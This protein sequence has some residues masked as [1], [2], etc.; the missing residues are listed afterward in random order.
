ME[1]AQPS[2][3]TK[4]RP[5]IQGLRAIAVGIVVLF[6]IWPNAIPGG[7][8]GVDVFFVISGFLITGLLVRE[9]ENSGRI[10]LVTF[11]ARRARRLLP[12]AA[13]VLVSVAVLTP[14]LLPAS[15]WSDVGYGV[16]ASLFY[17]ENWRL[18]AQAV[19]YLGAENAPGPVQH[20]WSLSVEEQFYIGWPALIIVGFAIARFTRAPVRLLLRIIFALVFAVSLYASVSLTASDPAQAYFVTH[21][22]VWELSLGGLLALGG[23]I[24]PGGLRR[25]LGVVGLI[26]IL[27]SALI[28]S[29]QTP[30]PGYA[31]LIPTL[32]AALV[33]LSGNS[34]RLLSAFSVL[35]TKPF[36]FLGDISY[37]VYLWHW[38]LLIFFRNEAGNMIEP[39]AGAFII[40]TTLGLAAFSKFQVEDVF[41]HPDPRTP[42][43]RRVVL[44]MSWL[45]AP[46]AGVSVAFGA[47]AYEGAKVAAEASRYPGAR[48]VVDGADVPPVASPAP[49]L[50]LLR[51][52]RAA[53]YD[54]GCHAK[55]EDSIPV[56]CR[57]GD[58]E[59]TY[60][61]FLIGDSHAANWIPALETLADERG[62]NAVSFTKSSCALMP[63][64]MRRSGAAYQ[65]CYDW[66]QRILEI[67][68]E[69][70]PDLVLHTQMYSHRTF[71]PATGE[72]QPSLRGSIVQIWREIEAMGPRV[73]AI[74]DTPRWHKDPDVCLS[75]D[76]ACAVPL[77]SVLRQDPLVDAQ[78]RAP[79][80]PI[81]SFVDV[82]CPDE[83]CSAV[84]GNVIV[85][86]DRHHITATYSRSMADVFG[87]RI[88][89][90]LEEH[91]PEK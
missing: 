69:E 8:V 3:A 1:T 75:E 9:A 21:T 28:Y 33:I 25:I 89:A 43:A 2:A 58:P 37:S 20:F 23:P 40:T 88:D 22:R 18:A 63:V 7:Y 15:Q 36:Q 84:V 13:L 17:V 70:K 46:L 71:A 45:L 72:T 74:A 49:S 66:G 85:W 55:F 65:E 79:D 68:R 34:D 54:N 51:K 78:R 87:R 29:I 48:A 32:G 26:A 81:I 83:R 50:A 59:G 56:A 47:V 77:A 61:V 31:A 90:A 38:P 16:L 76:P 24:L 6:H 67:I 44:F 10:R 12:A 86:R 64:M 41:R 11:Y 52:D 5:E 82:L 39:V 73:I 35:K 91:E 57:Y 4:I 80:V 30:F 27:A 53:A 42:L 14:L 62:W 19:D 60:K